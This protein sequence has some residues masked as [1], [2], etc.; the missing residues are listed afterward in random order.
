ME[1]LSKAAGIQENVQVPLMRT[2]AAAGSPQVLLSN[3]KSPAL[4]E[5][6]VI[7]MAQQ[8]GCMNPNMT[9]FWLKNLD[10]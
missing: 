10:Q 7:F 6:N 1:H 2:P 4:G 9:D 3:L 5:T 8:R